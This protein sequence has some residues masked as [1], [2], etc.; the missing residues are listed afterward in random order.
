MEN[1]LKNEKGFVA[2]IFIGIICLGLI[3]FGIYCS[4]IEYQN[5]E[6]VEIVVKDKYIKRYN[7]TDTYLVVS[8]DNE[9]YKITDL[10]FKG[11]FNSTDLYNQLEIG[12]KFKITT[13]GVRLEYFSMYKNINK[14]EEINN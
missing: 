4:F 9:T 1:T 14:I 3:I 2:I 12:K 8:E 7:D 13:T 11:K 10:L 5:E 6:T